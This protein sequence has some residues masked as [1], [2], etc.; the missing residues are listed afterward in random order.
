MNRQSTTQIVREL[1]LPYLLY[2]APNWKGFYDG[3]GVCTHSPF[4]GRS[5]GRGD[6]VEMEYGRLYQQMQDSGGSVGCLSTI[7]K[8]LSIESPSEGDRDS[9]VDAWIRICATM[10]LMIHLMPNELAKDEKV[11][12]LVRMFQMSNPQWDISDVVLCTRA[13]MLGVG[14]DRIETRQLLRNEYD[15]QSHSD[16]MRSVH[17]LMRKDER[18]GFGGT[19]LENDYAFGDDA[20]FTVVSHAQMMMRKNTSNVN[21]WYMSSYVYHIATDLCEERDLAAGINLGR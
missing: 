12:H 2:C 13:A 8:F 4:V 10:P 18:S 11:A 6:N 15:D 9:I 7:C 16:V 20:F 19:E 3:Y 17:F 21:T 14:Y 1:P 5:P